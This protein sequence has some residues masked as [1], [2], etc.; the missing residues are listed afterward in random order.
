M[1]DNYYIPFTKEMKKDYTILLPNML[2]MHFKMI[3]R[4]LALYGYK[5]DLLDGDGKEIAAMGLKYTHND[6]CYPALLVIGQFLLALESGKYDVH[7]TALIMFQTG[8][9]CRASNYI[10]LIRKAL[11]RAGYGFVPVI[12]M[13]V[14]GLEKHPGFSLT[15]PI[16]RR[17][18]YGV[19]Y[20][21]LLMSLVHQVRATEKHAGDAEALADAFCTRLAEEMAQKRVRYR[22]VKAN[23]TR[24]LDAFAAIEREDRPRVRVGVVGEIFVKYAPV[25]NNHLVD[26]LVSEG[27]EPV[28]PGLVDFCLYCVTEMHDEYTLYGGSWIKHKIFGFVKNYLLKKQK[29]L[30]D[31]V[32]THGVF[33][34][35]SPF[36]HTE[37]LAKDYISRGVTMGEGWLLTAEMLELAESGVPNIICVQPFGCLPN[38]ICGKGMMKPIK[39]RNPDVNIVAIDYDPGMSAVNQENRIKL[40]LANAKREKTE[41]PVP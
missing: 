12:S 38:H 27:A 32:K 2:P 26:F 21:D 20:A 23:Y 17:M 13:S 7:K 6:A 22:D 19:L 40:M 36:S 18:V 24:I 33:S 8:G 39:E 37:T 29:D 28:V 30:L 9:G 10:S 31:A 3:S 15:L 35:L 34:A 14:S 25:A 16:W 1:K 4:I 41:A 11:A 5:T